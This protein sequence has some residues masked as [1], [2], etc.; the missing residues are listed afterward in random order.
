MPTETAPGERS[1]ADM[2]VI[3]TST[4]KPRRPEIS[5]TEDGRARRS[6]RGRARSTLLAPLGR[7]GAGGFGG[8]RAFQLEMA[9]DPA[10]PQL[11]VPGEA[12]ELVDL[13]LELVDLGLEHT[14]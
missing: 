1:A 4:C 12:L 7:G 13:G 3:E 5:G 11:R 14:D 10:E 8:I 2:A 9:L 6:E